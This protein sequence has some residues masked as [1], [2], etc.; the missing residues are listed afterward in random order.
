MRRFALALCVVALASC[1]DSGNTSPN[2]TSLNAD[3]ALRRAPTKPKIDTVTRTPLDSL[4]IPDH[5]S[6][7]VGATFAKVAL[8]PDAFSKSADAVHPDIACLDKAWNGAR[9]WMLYTPYKNGDSGYENPSFLVAGNDTSWTT[10]TA[11]TNPIV[12]W[13]GFGAYNSDPDHAFEPGTKRLMQV[14]RVV[15]DSFNKIM[16]MSTTD[17]K[18]WTTPRLAFKERNH[19][20]ISPSLVIDRDRSAD[21]WYVRSG[22][23]GCNATSS[24]VVMRSA[25]PDSNQRTDQANWSAAVAVKMSIP[26]S[27]IWHID[28]ERV[29]PTDGYIAL[30]VAYQKGLTCGSS[31]LWLGTSADGVNWRTFAIPLFWRGMALAKQRAIGTWYRGTMRYD[32]AS[33]SLHVW[34]SGLA[35]ANWTIYHSAFKLHDVLGLLGSA[36][37]ADMKLLA[38][39]QQGIPAT[40]PMP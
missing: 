26:N 1:T 38:S 33:D 24:S 13:P 17:A 9:C 23:D 19:D 28:V 4:S 2:T 31:D 40:I 6:G 7:L 27:V 11:I 18:T 35:G 12:A 30:I 34:P 39:R 32:A 3:A 36:Q 37:S 8:P 10:P 29:S 5:L 25:M 15:A 21:M 14:Y 22:A 20:A 16:I